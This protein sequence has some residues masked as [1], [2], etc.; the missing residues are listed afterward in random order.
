MGNSTSTVVAPVPGKGETVSL[1]M[2]LPRGP[3]NCS[4]AKSD[5]SEMRALGGARRIATCFSST[6]PGVKVPHDVVRRLLEHRWSAAK[7]AGACNWARFE[8]LESAH[9]L[10]LTSWESNADN[11]VQWVPGLLPVTIAT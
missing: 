2:A 7:I 4:D 5:T 3:A 9:E 1:S 8:V 11:R 6:S 10:D